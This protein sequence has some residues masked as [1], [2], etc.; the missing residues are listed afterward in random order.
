MNV[1]VLLTIFIIWF[2][3]VFLYPEKFYFFTKNKSYLRFVRIMA[4]VSII[5]CI[6]VIVA[7]LS[8]LLT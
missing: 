4:I 6:L 7:L 1:Y 8:D 5:F 2:T 3:L